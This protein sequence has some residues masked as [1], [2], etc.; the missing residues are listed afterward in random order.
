MQLHVG[1]RTDTGRVREL[2]ED[3]YLIW[4]E[5]GLF[6]V[7]D[8]MGGCPAGEVASEM[9]ARS[10]ADYVGAATGEA[11]VSA[12]REDYLPQSQRLRQAVERSNQYIFDCARAEPLRAGMGT[13]VVGAWISGPLVSVVHVGDSRAY[14]WHRNHLECLTRD[15][16]LRDPEHKNVLTRVVGRQATVN[17][18]LLELAVQPDDYV[19]LCTDGLTNMV[20]EAAVSGAI[21]RLREPQRI[22]DYL[23]DAANQ[24][25]GVD[26]ATVVVVEVVGGMWRSRWRH[27]TRRISGGH[28]ATVHSAS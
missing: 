26:N 22:C 9:A 17:V 23:I 3:V 4:P 27:W 20:S 13:T 8:G 28:G 10:I 16:S 1:A 15:H 19:L 12:P 6:L 5:H 24:N 11:A 25:G 7:C 14:L 21:A 2:N 18:E